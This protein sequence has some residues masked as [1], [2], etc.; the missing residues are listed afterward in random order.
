MPSMNKGGHSHRPRGRIQ[1]AY[2]L[3]TVCEVRVT[4]SGDGEKM[5]RPTWP[6]WLPEAGRTFGVLTDN[7]EM[8]M[9]I[10]G[11]LIIDAQVWIAKL[12]YVSRRHKRAIDDL[13]LADCYTEAVCYC[14]AHIV[15][16]FKPARAYVQHRKRKL[17]KDLSVGA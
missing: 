11:P 17:S 12:G 8:T 7:K 14:R 5:R 2:P 9:I 15:R 10:I 1:Q 16:E 3:T 13:L 6:G 4:H